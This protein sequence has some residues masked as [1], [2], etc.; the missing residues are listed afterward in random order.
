MSEGR[1]PPRP[2][3]FNINRTGLVIGTGSQ[4]YYDR[5][6]YRGLRPE[7]SEASDRKAALFKRGLVAA[8]QRTLLAQTV[9]HDSIDEVEGSA[10]HSE[11]HHARA[12]ATPLNGGA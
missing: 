1:S 10:S 6:Q 5:Y 11:G 4:G 2:D 3:F 8:S 12:K 7:L 9:L